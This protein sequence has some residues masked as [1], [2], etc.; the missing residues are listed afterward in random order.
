MP[1]GGT[2]DIFE[3]NMWIQGELLKIVESWGHSL[4]MN[5]IVESSPT[6]SSLI[7]AHLMFMHLMSNGLCDPLVEDR[8]QQYDDILAGFLKLTPQDFGP[9]KMIH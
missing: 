2:G 5:T 9:L 7:F 4:R 6:S 1:F 3:H 8:P